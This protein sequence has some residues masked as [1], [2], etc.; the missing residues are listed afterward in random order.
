MN[1][2]EFVYL[3]MIA[4]SLIIGFIVGTVACMIITAK[5]NKALKE[6]LDRVN[7]LYF[8]EMDRWKTKYDQSDY[9]AY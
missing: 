1:D 5:E 2:S 8:E 3:G 9:E 6:E 4:I 7:D